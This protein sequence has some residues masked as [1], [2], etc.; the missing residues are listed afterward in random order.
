MKIVLATKNRGKIEEIKELLKDPDAE[1]LTLGDFPKLK[2]PAEKAAS[3]RENALQKAR[4]AAQKT[5]IPS[6]A[7]DSGL[8]VDFLGK[9]PGVLS[10]RYAGAGASDS[11][12]YLKL[13]KELKGV[14]PAKRTA[15]FRCVIAFATPEGKE[16]TFT[17]LFEGVIGS[18]P[19]GRGGFGYDP[20]FID[21]E[22]GKTL[23]QLPPREKNRIS[24][25]GRALEK[26]RSWLLKEG[27]KAK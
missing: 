22:T 11:D 6:I 10:A 21:P 5:G 27:K 4:F 23:A 20:V 13:L 26:L 1:V 17:G 9:R 19:K 15:R 14:L 2:L 25:R 7:D 24:H 8:Q 12:N 3:F 16:K 18:H